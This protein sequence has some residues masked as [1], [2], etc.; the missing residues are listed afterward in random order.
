MHSL[1]KLTIFEG[2]WSLHF[3]NIVIFIMTTFNAK[4]ILVSCYS[5]WCYTCLRMKMKFIIHY[6]NQKKQE[7]VLFTHPP[8]QLAGILGTMGLIF[9]VILCTVTI[10]M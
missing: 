3:P 6:G 4:D 1:L 10:S 9:S 5:K 2:D 7:S 8:L